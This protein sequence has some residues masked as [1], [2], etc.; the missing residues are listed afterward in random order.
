MISEP[1]KI[2][3]SQVLWDYYVIVIKSIYKYLF[4]MFIVQHKGCIKNL[5]SIKNKTK[6]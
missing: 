5:L 1:F 3:S 6:L 2:Y 4:D